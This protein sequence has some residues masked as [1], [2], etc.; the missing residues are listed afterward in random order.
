MPKPATGPK[1]NCKLKASKPSRWFGKNNVRRLACPWRC[2]NSPIV[3]GAATTTF[4]FRPSAAFATV[5]AMPT[6]K[7]KTSKPKT[8]TRYS[9]GEWYGAGFELLTP[10]ERFT[11]AKT[12]CETDAI[13]GVAC[14]FQA[15][16][17]CN[18]KGGVC[19]LRQYQQI[20][21]DPV[22][23]VGPV[24]TTCPQRFLENNAIFQWV[25]ETLLQTKDAVV[26]S[27]IG[28][29]DRLRS[30]ESEEGEDEDSSD[31][32]GRI[33]NVLVHPSRQPMDWCA[34]ELQAVYFSGKSMAN[35]FKMMA[36][37]ENESVPFPAKHRRPDWRS[38]GPKR[39]LPQLQTKVPT[40]RTWGKKMAVVIDEAFFVTPFFKN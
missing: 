26:L 7:A 30:E 38:S 14:P 24:I 33:D 39:L 34:L 13:L 32:I 3:R 12:E 35:E 1:A 2:L 28:F 27:E 23:G 6:P 19:S 11:R 21:D 5:S 29:L 17:K 8:R 18:K 15:D 37:K 20:G 16:A 36:E 31:F 4:S 40:I 9:I 22:T 10:A 25:G